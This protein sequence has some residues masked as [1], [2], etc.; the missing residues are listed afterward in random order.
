MSCSRNGVSLV[1]REYSYRLM[2]PMVGSQTM[3]VGAGA[4]GLDT[5]AEVLSAEGVVTARGRLGGVSSRVQTRA[6]TSQP[7]PGA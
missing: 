1:G 6:T 2:A 5:E 3:A 4:D 7:R